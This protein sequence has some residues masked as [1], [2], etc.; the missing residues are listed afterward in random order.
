MSFKEPREDDFTIPSHLTSRE[1]GKVN[2]RQDG[3]AYEI[4]FTILMAPQGKDAE[5][6]QTG[7]ALD[8]SISMKSSFGQRLV[9]KLPPDVEESYRKRGWLRKEVKDGKPV[10]LFRQEAY[11]DAQRL[12]HFRKSPNIVQPLA[13]DFVGYLADELDA[14]GGTT[15][16]Y[17]ACGDGSQY[18]V[19]GDFTR[20]QIDDVKI[21]GPSSC[22]FGAGT[23]LLPAMR[24][25]V[26][27]FDN[28]HRGMYLFVTDGRL[29]DLNALKQY[30][31]DLA[32]KIARGERNPIKCVLIGVGPGID[33]GQMNELD[34]LD[35]DVEIDIWDYKLAREMRDILEIFAEVVDEHKIIAPHG[36]LYDSSGSVV[37]KYTDGLPARVELRVPRSTEWFELEVAGQRI[38]QPIVLPKPVI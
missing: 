38:R 34:D 19:V 27:R 11:A 8:A 29:D 20:A 24:Y 2:I 33:E 17:W 23:S 3:D 21:E 36:V 1:F 31:V 15:L 9:G 4:Q 22:T 28:A 25:F 5:G 18:E 32:Q 30:S 16:I 14:D 26:E 37:K 35:T 13:R 10:V 7:V 6:W 12:G